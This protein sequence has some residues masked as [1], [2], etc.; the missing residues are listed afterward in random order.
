MIFVNIVVR[1]WCWE[2]GEMYSAPVINILKQ[3]SQVEHFGHECCY[4]RPQSRSI[5]SQTEEVTVDCK[6]SVCPSV[7]TDTQIR[8]SELLLIANTP[9]W[10]NQRLI[11]H[12][13]HDFCT[14]T[15]PCARGIYVYCTYKHQT[16]LCFI[17]C[18]YDRIYC[19]DQYL[20][21]TAI[22]PNVKFLATFLQNIP[23]KLSK[24]IYLHY[25]K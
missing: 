15:N 24:K 13:N 1:S 2:W 22:V 11:G 19:S 25:S 3:L 18:A 6:R 23:L 9:Q 5:R 4:R 12:M 21:C 7:I 14:H 20:Y 10:T 16:I 17:Y 8:K